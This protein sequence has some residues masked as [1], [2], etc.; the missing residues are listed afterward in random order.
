MLHLFQLILSHVLTIA[1][2]IGLVLLTI[3]YWPIVL[4][5]VVVSTVCLYIAGIIGY[6]RK[7]KTYR[8]L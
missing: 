2:L 6:L 3:A 7:N 8:D 4:G 5:V 1:F